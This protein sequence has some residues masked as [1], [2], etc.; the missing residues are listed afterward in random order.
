MEKLFVVLVGIDYEAIDTFMGA[1]STRE[2]AEK[3]LASETIQW[4]DS[5]RI[6]EVEPNTDWNVF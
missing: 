3:R 6:V 4:F 2:R 5:K 1:Y